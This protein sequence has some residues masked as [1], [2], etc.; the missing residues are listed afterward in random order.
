MDTE[1]HVRTVIAE[2]HSE[3][4]RQINAEGWT[5]DHDDEHGNAQLAAAAAAYAAHAASFRGAPELGVNYRIKTPHPLWPWGHHWWKPKD[6][7]R[8][9]VRAA[10]LIVAEIERLDRRVKVRP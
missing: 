6:P 4:L 5:S 10:A 3:R 7:R 8:D 2:I 9:L 1:N